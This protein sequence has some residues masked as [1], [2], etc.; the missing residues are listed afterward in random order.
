[1]L[2]TRSATSKPV[3]KYVS[4]VPVAGNAMRRDLEP[5]AERKKRTRNERQN[6][7]ER[8]T[9]KR[10][11]QQRQDK[12]RQVEH[13]V[14]ASFSLW[15]PAQC[16]FRFSH[17]CRSDIPSRSVHVRRGQARRVEGSKRVFVLL[18]PSHSCTQ[19]MLDL[20]PNN[21]FLVLA[22]SPVT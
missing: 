22:Y 7:A 15:P 18:P 1:M 10:W 6:K 17:G 19:P 16:K 20:W 21:G 13:Y 8:S 2:V 3:D 9:S 4:M 5:Q 14:T 12:A 11:A